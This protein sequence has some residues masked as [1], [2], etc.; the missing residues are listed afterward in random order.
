M[1][2]DMGQGEENSLSVF[3]V[4][5]MFNSSQNHEYECPFCFAQCQIILSE[6]LMVGDSAQI[7]YTRIQK[8]LNQSYCSPS[9]QNFASSL[10]GTNASQA[11]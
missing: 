3:E 4:Q 6:S 11:Q 5:S 10:H 7:D 1:L 2:V 8:N 9:R